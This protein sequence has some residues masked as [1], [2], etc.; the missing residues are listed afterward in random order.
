VDA[1][2]S[3][4][5]IGGRVGARIETLLVAER[6]R[7]VRVDADLGEPLDALITFVDAGGKRLRPAFCHWAF[8]GAGGTDV[9]AVTDA[10]AALELLHTFAL[11]HDDVM[12]DSPVRRGAPSIHALFANRHADREW[13]GEHRRFGESVAILV[14]DLAFVYADLLMHGA[15]ADAHHVFTE[16][17][18]EVNIGQYLDVRAGADGRHERDRARR[19]SVLKSGKYT[20]ERPLHL[21]AALAGRLDELGPGL[22]AYGIP[23]GEAFQM[24]D[25]LLGAFGEELLVGKPVGDDLREGKVTELMSAAREMATPAALAVLDRVG[26]ADLTDDE[27]RRLQEVLVETGARDAME[28]RIHEL[29]GRAVEALHAVAL[30]GDASAELEGLAAYIAAREM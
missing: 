27:V 30:D 21:G 9:D 6:D 20:V 4:A 29:T 18:V 23:L 15:P 24:R 28:A 14:G 12:D 1:P 17:R 10:G 13:R 22:T 8:V 11:V 3:L 7:W 19:I 26:A 25:D 5:D 2:A 16:L